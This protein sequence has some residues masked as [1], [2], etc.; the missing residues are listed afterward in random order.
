M[1]QKPCTEVQCLVLKLPY[2]FPLAYGYSLGSYG[3]YRV[4]SVLLVR[5]SELSVCCASWLDHPPL[6]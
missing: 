1:K 4:Y 5:T 2:K 3:R 6:F